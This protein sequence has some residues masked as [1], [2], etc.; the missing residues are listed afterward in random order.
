MSNLNKAERDK[1][2]NADF[3]DPKNRLYPIVDQDDVDSAAHLIGK[4]DDPEVVKRRIIAIAKRKGLK[5]PDAWKEDKKADMAA[6]EAAGEA[7]VEGEIVLRTGKYFE[8][9][10]DF[11]DRDGKVFGLKTP[12]EADAALDRFAPAALNLHHED[13]VFDALGIELG[14]VTRLWRDGNDIMAEYA[15]P[16]WLHDGTQG[17]PIPMSSEWDLETVTPLGAA[18]VIE[19]AVSDAVMMAAFSSG[20]VSPDTVARF[21]GTR[22][23]TPEG[24]TVIQ[25]LHDVA[26]RAGAIC[27]RTNAAKM[28]AQHEATV[29]QKVHDMCAEHGAKCSSGDAPLWAR[30][31]Y[32][33]DKT[34]PGAKGEKTMSDKKPSFLDAL[35]AL[36]HKAGVSETDLQPLRDAEIPASP[37]VAQFTRERDAMRAELS[38]L[39]SERIEEQAAAFAKA[40]IDNAR[41]MPYE[42]ETLIAQFT[43]AAEDDAAAPKKVKFSKIG[44]DGKMSEQE[45]S[46]VEAFMAAV[47]ARAPHGYTQEMLGGDRQ[48]G[49]E[50]FNVLFSRGSDRETEEEKKKRLQREADEE[51]SKTDAGRKALALREKNGAH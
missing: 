49:P 34:A 14:Q 39:R 13:S 36:F 19:P 29:F 46:R 18:M 1:R 23:N 8:I 21:A 48:L 31:M 22:H 16:K 27:D 20:R 17:K 35:A 44:A 3:G 40:A 9:G 32:S 10:Q 24:Q 7:R 15:I 42:R 41:A 6:F 45:G 33:R 26:A 30:T 28:A 5:I 25:N 43:Q 37:D 51:L 11:T 50:D 4:A 47:A 38:A 2:P 12:D